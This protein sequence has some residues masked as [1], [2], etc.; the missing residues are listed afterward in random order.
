MYITL[1]QFIRGSGFELW[2]LYGIIPI[3]F[4]GFLIKF[5]RLNKI[6]NSNKE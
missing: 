2:L 5:L 4:I 6:L 3:L 1:I